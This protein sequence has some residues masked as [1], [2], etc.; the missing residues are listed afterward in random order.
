MKLRPLRNNVMFQ[1]LED[2]GGQK[3]RF[4]ERARASG[5]IIPPTMS[6]QKVAR[7]GRV[8]AA[9]PLAEVKEDDLI[10]VEAMMWMEGSKWENGQ[11][12]K[13]DD[14]KILAI[15]DDI[16]ECQSQAL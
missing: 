6:A 12:W 15:T 9:G 7:W 13:T 10:L 4:H 16:N 2:T 11:V 8:V 5:I 3:G 14:T 1:F